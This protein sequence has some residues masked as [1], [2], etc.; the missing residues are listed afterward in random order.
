M[1]LLLLWARRARQGTGSYS[2]ETLADIVMYAFL[3]LR[4][5]STLVEASAGVW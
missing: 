4:A 5:Q 1:L 3:N 2:D